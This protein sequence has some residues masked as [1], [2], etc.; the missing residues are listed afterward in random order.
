MKFPT[1]RLTIKLDDKE[2]IGMTIGTEKPNLISI[3]KD[4]INILEDMENGKLKEIVSDKDFE[5]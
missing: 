1:Q 3:L 4:L 5:G 2:L